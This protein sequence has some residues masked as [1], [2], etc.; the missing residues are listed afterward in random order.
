MMQVEL[1]IAIPG[2]NTITIS[3]RC[4][5]N[6]VRTMPRL[7]IQIHAILAM[8]ILGV[9]AHGTEVKPV[10]SKLITPPGNEQEL[11][12]VSVAYEPGESSRSHRH[13]AHT[14]VYVLE[15]AIVMQVK[16]WRR[17]PTLH[18]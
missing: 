13:N 5:Y 17:I 18:P 11:L 16:P 6:E 2:P 15:G 1:V 14:L 10:F 8:L 9:S 12:V 3:S 7:S 4:S